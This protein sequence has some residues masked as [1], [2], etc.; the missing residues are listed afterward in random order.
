[1]IGEQER[2]QHPQPTEETRIQWRRSVELRR[3]LGNPRQRVGVPT[4]T[5]VEEPPASSSAKRYQVG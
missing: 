2:N 5:E 1:M 3:V 4:S